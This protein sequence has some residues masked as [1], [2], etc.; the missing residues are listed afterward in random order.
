VGH[1][2]AVRSVAQE[3][4]A[5]LTAQPRTLPPKFFYDARGSA[6]FDEITR[7]PEYYLTSA[8]RI[9]L[10]AWARPWLREV[11]VRTLA[12]LGPGN[13]D[14]A[15]LLLS[16]PDSP[17]RCYVPVDIS[18]TYLRQI[19]EHMRRDLPRLRVHPAQSDIDTHLALPADVDRPMV[20]AI[21]GSTIGNFEDGDA[22]VLL[23]RIRATLRPD[24]RL[25]LGCDL[26]KDEDT[27]TAA[28]NDPGGVTAAFNRN[29]LRVLNRD[30]GTDF[31]ESE[32][33]HLAYFDREQSR[34]E[35]HLRA[36]SPQRVH[37]PD[38]GTVEIRAGETIRTEIS[39]KYD[40]RRIERLF[41]AA[42]LR[43]EEWEEGDGRFALAVGAPEATG[44]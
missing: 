11:G 31:E 29:V 14:K 15:R 39:I 8:E 19:A 32:F 9:L 16:D 13:G 26:S 33:E 22:I 2:M 25:L 42:G 37:M 27:L 40:R 36:R 23:S 30:L 5:G 34:I 41:A 20:V 17:I 18:E 35:M 21:L 24:D 1:Q 10:D 44:A 6:L 38:C 28:Y 43:V 12:E 4:W 3:A 7:L